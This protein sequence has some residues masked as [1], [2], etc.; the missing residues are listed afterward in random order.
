VLSCPKVHLIRK[1]TCDNGKNQ[2]HFEWLFSLWNVQIPPS[3][4]RKLLAKYLAM[5]LHIALMKERLYLR[6]KER[7]LYW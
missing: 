6:P 7:Y 4:Q 3:M 2:A 5:L 1:Y